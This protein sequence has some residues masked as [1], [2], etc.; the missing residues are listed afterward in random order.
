MAG[1]LATVNYFLEKIEVCLTRKPY[2]VGFRFESVVFAKA[3][4]LDSRTDIFLTI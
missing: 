2:F 1:D 4:A 3:E